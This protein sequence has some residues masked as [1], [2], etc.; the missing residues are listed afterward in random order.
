MCPL[1]FGDELLKCEVERLVAKCYC[2]LE[3]RRDA[4]RWLERALDTVQD[5]LAM[6]VLPRQERALKQLRGE[7]VLAH[8]A[9]IL[10]RLY[11]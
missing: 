3:K 1:E 5:M 2:S 8:M 7:S 4:R 11:Q 10:S 9:G 6:L